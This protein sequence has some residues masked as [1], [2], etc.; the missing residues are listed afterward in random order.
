[1]TDIKLHIDFILLT[2]LKSL[3]SATDTAIF[4]MATEA[5]V[6]FLQQITN[7]II[8]LRN[9]YNKSNTMYNHKT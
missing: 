1:M 5:A 7:T 4:L 6:V 2:Y 8:E 3:L 9:M